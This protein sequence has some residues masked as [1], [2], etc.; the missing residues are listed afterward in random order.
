MLLMPVLEP[1]GQR[2]LASDIQRQEK[3]VSQLQ[4]RETKG[5][6]VKG[7]LPLLRQL[8]F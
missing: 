6:R 7:N 2:T 5:R 3:R 1:N 8:V 4:E